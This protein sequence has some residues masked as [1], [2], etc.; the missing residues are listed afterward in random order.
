MRFISHRSHRRKWVHPFAFIGAAITATASATAPYQFDLGQTVD[1]TSGLRLARDFRATVV[2]EKLEPLRHIAVRDNGDIHAAVSG[3]A[4]TGIYVLRDT[5]GDHKADQV[6]KYGEV[7]G[8]GIAIQGGYVYRSS[9]TAIYRWRLREGEFLPSG[10]RE[11][12]ADGLASKS[13]HTAKSIT[14]DDN[15]HIFVNVGAPSNACQERRHTRG[16]PGK[17]P[18]P[19]LRRYGGIW[20]FDANKTGQD[21]MADGY[22]YATGIRNA[23]A[24]AWNPAVDALYLVQHGRDQL[25]GLWPEHFSDQENAELPAEEF[26][27]VE[28]G[29]T[30]GW[31]Y[32]YYDHLRGERMV[33]PEYGGDG[34]TPAESGKY[35]D[36]IMAFPGHWAPNGLL[37]YTGDQFPDIFRGG[38]FIAFHG[39]WNRSPLAQEGYKVAFAPFDDRKPRGPY[40]V[41]AD[42]FAGHGPVRNPREAE[43]RPMGLAQGPDGELYIADS[44]KGT[45]WRIDYV[46]H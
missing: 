13:Q 11:T 45:I 33:A 16:S 25:S 43:H 23:V 26:L 2:V 36:P 4:G 19:L 14:L 7:G 9:D 42:G 12:V 32:T 41:F 17:S 34:K 5:D 22:R 37:F 3:R 30:H 1:P 15:G 27:L 44:V 46:G 18:C 6:K 29:A 21:Q 39:S 40:H 31:P 20:R 10:P 38:A 28:D 24:L 35:P 8:T